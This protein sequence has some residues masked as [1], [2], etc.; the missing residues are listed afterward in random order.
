MANYCLLLPGA[1]QTWP[2]AF[3]RCDA[4]SSDRLGTR[5]LASKGNIL[6]IN[7]DFNNNDHRG[8]VGV[9]VRDHGELGKLARTRILAAALRRGRGPKLAPSITSTRV[10]VARF[11]PIRC[12]HPHLRL[13]AGNRPVQFRLMIEG[14]APHRLLPSGEFDGTTWYRSTIQR[15]E[16]A[17]SFNGHELLRMY[18]LVNTSMKSRTARERQEIAGSFSDF[19][20]TTALSGS[21]GNDVIHLGGPRRRPLNPHAA[22]HVVVTHRWQIMYYKGEK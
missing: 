5:R 10:V 18:R 7:S 2:R 9:H 13:R 14:Y 16:L 8:L 17:N 6:I 21:T 20:A 15:V 4:R 19:S 11:W 3:H 1:P 22:E 12:L